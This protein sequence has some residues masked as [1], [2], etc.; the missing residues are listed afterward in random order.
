MDNYADRH[1]RN[2]ITLLITEMWNM[3]PDVELDY[4]AINNKIPFYIN[5]MLFTTPVN[6]TIRN[7][8][9]ERKK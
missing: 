4:A 1:I 9:Y 7:I 8:M 3:L 5:N 6:T 2:T